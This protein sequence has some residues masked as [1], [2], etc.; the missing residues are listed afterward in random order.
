MNQQTIFLFQFILNF[1]GIYKPK[2]NNGGS[3]SGLHIGN[4]TFHI[5]TRQCGEDCEERRVSLLPWSACSPDMP[6]IEDVWVMVS[7]H[8][9]HHDPPR[10]LI[11]WSKFTQLH[12]QPLFD[13]MAPHLEALIATIEG[14]TLYWNHMVT[15]HVEFCDSNHLYCRSSNQWYKF[16]ISRI[17]E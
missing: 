5:S 16:H 12:N 14:F 17:V 2:H 10:K 9:I 3:F 6:P 1:I 13:S 8:I 11:A 15:D 7:R 4:S